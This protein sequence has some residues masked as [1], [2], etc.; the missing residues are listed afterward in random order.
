VLEV[1]EALKLDP[2]R[3]D[4][5]RMRG[6]LSIRLERYEDADR[7]YT[8]LLQVQHVAFDAAWL[9]VARARRG[10]DAR[11][12]LEQE[13]AGIKDGEWPAPILLFQLE[14]LDRDG[15][16]GT[17]ARSEEKQRKGRECEARYFASQ[18][19]LLDG[20][21]ADARTL[22]EKVEADCPRNYLEYEAAIGELERLRKE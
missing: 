12:L 8:A 18:R 22:L 2:T 15:L 14:R 13:L 1:D 21:K 20:A 6:Q 17:A 9:H 16:L 5:L 3:R 11:A 19:F 10:L 4:A 7:D